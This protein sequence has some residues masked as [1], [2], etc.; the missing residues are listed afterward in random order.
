[1]KKKVLASLLAVILLLCLTGVANASQNKIKYNNNLHRAGVLQSA[2]TAGYD[3][4]LVNGSSKTFLVPAGNSAAAG[5]AANLNKKVLVRGIFTRDK[6]AG[7]N[8]MEVFDVKALTQK[9]YEEQ[10]QNQE[11]EEEGDQNQSVSDSVYGSGDFCDLGNDYSWALQA[12]REMS[13]KKI[14]QGTGDNKFEPAAYITRAQFATML[15]NALGIPVTDPATQTFADV[16]KDD[17]SYKYVEA[18][19]S[20]LTGY[21]N[22]AGQIMFY[23]QMPAVRE[24]MAVAIVKALGFTP[25]TDLTVLDRFSDKDDI[26]ASVLPYVATAINEGLM[27]GYENCTFRPQGKLTRAEAAVLIYRVMISEKIVM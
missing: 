5:L 15:V 22:Q 20:Y 26:S 25:A 27:K 24:D 21:K 3:F 16:D 7:K 6:F 13:R 17:W 8:I 10:E 18:A 23:P 12:I 19:M 9:Q 2:A 11:Q 14:I 4:V 1:V